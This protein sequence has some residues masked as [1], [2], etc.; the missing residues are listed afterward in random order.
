MRKTALTLLTG[1]FCVFANAQEAD[2]WTPVEESSIGRNVFA[3]RF[4]PSSFKLFKLKETDL[5]LN[6]GKVPSEVTVPAH[7]SNSIL[8]VPTGTGEIE[9]FRLVEAPVLHPDLARRYP[10]IKSYAGKG[11]E[12][13]ASTIRVDISPEGMHAIILSPDRPT[14]YIDPVD[15]TDKYYVVFTRTDANDREPFQCMTDSAVSGALAD[16]SMLRNADDGRLRTYRLALAATGEYSAFFLNGTETTVAERKAKVLAA[17]NTAITR[18]NAIYERDF[19]IRLQLVANNDLIIYLSASTDPW[20]TEFNST[21]QVTIDNVIGSGYYD[22]GHLV[23][24]STNNGNAGCIACVC[25]AGA[26]GS[27]YTSHKTPQGDPFVVDYLSHEIAHQFGAN[28]TFSHVNEGTPWQV[29]P[30]SGS[31][32]MGYAGI[33]GTTTDVQMNSDDYFHARSIEQVTNFI[34]S[35]TAGGSCPVITITENNFPLSNAGADFV[36]PKSTPFVL[37]G[38]GS[39]ADVSDLLT[40]TWEQTDMKTGTSPTTPSATATAGPVFRSLKPAVSASRM[41]PVLSSVLD[42]TNG[43]KW[44]VLPSV[45]RTLNFRFTVRDNHTGGGNNK[46]DDVV[47]SVAGTAGPFAVSSPNTNISWSSGSQQAI[48]WTVNGTNLSPVNCS[49]VSIHLSTDGGLTFPIILSEATP[50]DGEETVT[51]PGIASSRCR[52]RVVSVGNIFFDISNADFTIGAA[53]AT[54]SPAT[55]LTTSNISGS[56]ATISWS[57]SVDAQ[58]CTVDYRA[59]S[60]T[61][62]TSIALSTTSGSASISGLTPGTAYEWRVITNCS[63]ASGNPATAQFTTA[64]ACVSNFEGNETLA[65]ATLPPTNTDF[66]A[67][68]GQGSDKDWYKFSVVS[69]STVHIVLS[70]LPADY[71]FAMYTT[72]GSLIAKSENVGLSDEVITNITASAGTYYIQVYGVNG[73]F[74]AA[75]CY[76]MNIGLLPICP[77][78]FDVQGNTSMSTAVQIPFSHDVKGQISDPLD[79]DYFKF[80]VL[81]GGTLSVTLNTLPADYD[82]KLLNSAG[83]QVGISQLRGTTSEIINYTALAGTYYLNIYGYKSAYH[84]SGCY[85]LK[86]NPGT[87]TGPVSRTEQIQENYLSLYPNPASDN[88]LVEMT[89]GTDGAIAEVYDSYGT[90]RLQQQVTGNTFSLAVKQL[91]AGVYLVK[92]RN[93]NGETSTSRFIKK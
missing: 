31:T 9:R 42:G 60:S 76:T 28:H 18:T 4:K 70:A 30:G 24:R 71:D 48:T 56:G 3:N 34:K 69:T 25:K 43:N 1:I 10:N 88:L 50:N 85:T 79:I 22:I 39:D 7:R 49:T 93:R 38:S 90:K 75:G 82:V 12:N 5:V 84:P 57:T 6:L 63:G 58:S 91:P 11:V 19:G 52:I 77:G 16:G 86:I 80:S 26:K 23:H 21:T 83:K 36:I 37:T 41:F 47:V 89:I 68:I 33:T 87:A 29:E 64:A 32:I 40:Y 59:L 17:Q 13:P 51:L 53:V 65:T 44:E 35:A 20:S 27:G 61:T 55:A 72:S 67:A 62:W 74:N 2:Y 92:V 81:T 8:K 73:S 15:R 54:C 66:T 45:Q 46:S 14:I 78:S